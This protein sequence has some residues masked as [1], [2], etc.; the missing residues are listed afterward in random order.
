[1]LIFS[2]SLAVDRLASYNNFMSEN[3]PHRNKNEN[4]KTETSALLKTG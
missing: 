2:K 3:K 4:M 1:M